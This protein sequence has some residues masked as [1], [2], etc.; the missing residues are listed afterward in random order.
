MKTKQAQNFYPK[1]TQ[2]LWSWFSLVLVTA[3]SLLVSVSLVETAR[4]SSASLFLAPPSGTYTA[5]STF[6]VAVKVNSGGGIINAAEASLIF[7]PSELKVIN[8]SQT[9]SIFTLWTTEP[10]FSNVNGNISFGG[11]T[12]TNFTGTSGTIIT[13]NF[14][15]KAITSAQISFSS[16]AIL[17]ADGQGT[18]VLANM[19]GGTYNLKS[20][21]ITPPAEGVP[22]EVLPSE[23]IVPEKKY[24]PPAASGKTPTA[25]LVSSATHPDESQWYSNK[26]PEFS[27]QLPQDVTAVRLLMGDKP[28]GY[29]TVVYTSPISEKKV[30]DLTDG[31][32]YFHVQFKNQYGW[33]GITHRKVFID[34]VSPEPF[35]IREDNE[36]DPTNPSPILFFETTDSLSGLAYYEIKIDSKEDERRTPEE[37]Q[38]EPY[39]LPPQT[40]GKRTVIVKAFDRAGNFTMASVDV[41]IEA[42]ER[43][44]ITDFPET[45]R[46]GDILTIKGTSLYPEAT[47][48]V[49]VKKE[50]EEPRVRDVKTGRQG[51][52]LF[53]YDKSLE[54]GTYQLWSQITDSRGA[55]SNPTEKI[56]LVASLPTILKF[57]KMAIDYL[58]VMLTLISLIIVLILVIFY[59][60]YRISLWQKKLRQE[61]KEVAQSVARSFRALR[62]EVQE[63]VECLDKKPGLSKDEKALR[64][65]LKEALNISEEF[66]SKEIKDVEKELE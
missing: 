63:Q 52:W 65:K 33:G 19:V 53:I 49:F 27:W 24:P 45:L 61:T 46:V 58:T 51:D 28:T 20:G 9:G 43:P 4:A 30:E 23:E 8:V 55:K 13:I 48:T 54:K 21:I 1:Q 50:G 14:Q 34:S 42:L 36:G 11:G 16:G 10:T 6:P 3:L 31:V 18:N 62:E 41:I 44:V 59:S 15:A 22:S 25:P 64:D 12:P 35:E 56:T 32:W 60:W 7:N 40:P 17:A 5:G 2:N 57:G 38:K 37:L 47:V 26:N 66:I 39:K 29:P